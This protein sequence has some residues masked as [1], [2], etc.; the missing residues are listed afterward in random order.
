[1]FSD[2]SPSKL[3][4][5]FVTRMET[6]TVGIT[7]RNHAHRIIREHIGKSIAICDPKIFHMGSLF[8]Y[9]LVCIHCKIEIFHDI[10]IEYITSLIVL[11]LLAFPVFLS[12]LLLDPVLFLIVPL[13]TVT[14]IVLRGHSKC[15]LCSFTN[16]YTDML[17]LKASV[18]LAYYTVCLKSKILSR[19]FSNHFITENVD[20]LTTHLQ[21][22]LLVNRQTNSPDWAFDEHPCRMR[23]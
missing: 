17:H 3:F 2:F 8:T 15:N 23:L 16:Q 7:S 1:M 19:A 10:F 9:V 14:H 4:Q 22:S 5:A 18:V 11:N 13:S 6:K 20:S 21:L 12:P